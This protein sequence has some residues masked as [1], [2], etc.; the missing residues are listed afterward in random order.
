MLLVLF[1][2]AAAPPLSLMIPRGHTTSIAQVAFSNDGKLLASAGDDPSVHLWDVESGV[3]LKRLPG[4]GERIQGI[5]F[6]PTGALLAAVDGEPIYGESSLTVWSV[7]SGQALVTLAEKA[8]G[9]AF[10]P[11]GTLLVT[12]AKHGVVHVW[13]VAE[14]KSGKATPRLLQLDAGLDL[15][16]PRFS[17]DGKSLVVRS[18]TTILKALNFE[19]VRD[20]SGNGLWRVPLSGKPT[21]LASVAPSAFSFTKRGVIAQAAPSLVLGSKTIIAAPVSRFAVSN[22]DTSVFWSDESAL[23]VSTLATGAVQRTAQTRVPIRAIAAHPDGRRFVTGDEAG[24]LLEWSSEL[25]V[26]RRFGGDTLVVPRFSLRPDGRR[27]ARVEGRRVLLYDLEAMTPTRTLEGHAHEVVAVRFDPANRWLASIDEQSTVRLWDAATGSEQG[28]IKGLRGQA[29]SLSFSRDG[30]LLFVASKHGSIAVWSVE[31]QRVL[32]TIESG[33]DLGD[34]VVAANDEIVAVAHASGDHSYSAYR[35]ADGAKIFEGAVSRPDGK[36]QFFRALRTSSDGKRLIGLTSQP[37]RL[38][39]VDARTGDAFSLRDVDETTRAFAV[40]PEGRGYAIGGGRASWFSGRISLIRA[41]DGGIEQSLGGHESFILDAQFAD[42]GVLATSANDA[43]LR[44]WRPHE[45]AAAVT[46]TFFPGG[47]FAAAAP[48]GRFEG[49]PGGVARL[50]LVRGLEHFALDAFFERW[51]SPGMLSAAMRGKQL[52]S[53]GARLVDSPVAPAVVRFVTP[54]S[55]TSTSDEAVSVTVEAVDQGGG[56]DEIRLYQNGKLVSEPLRGAKKVQRRGEVSRQS[57]SLV[58]AAGA[59]VFRVVALSASRVESVAA[60]RTVTLR[61]AVPSARLHVV[62]VGI[63]AYEN[64]KYALNYG[65]PDAE[66][67][68][69]AL[70]EGASRIFAGVDR[71]LLFDASATK[72]G[73]ERALVEVAAKAKPEDAFVFYYAGHGAMSEGNAEQSPEFHLAPVDVR[74]L[75]GDDAE[76]A[77]AG[78]SAGRLKELI[79]RI[80]A[81][82]QLIVFDACQSGGAVDAFARRGAAEERAIAQLARATGVMVIAAT[83]TEQFAS[84]LAKLGHGVFTYALLQGLAGKADRSADGKITVKE[85]EAY[86]NDAVPELTKRYRGA[87]QYPTGY[88][89]GQDFPLVVR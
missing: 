57:F 55:D 46:M 77:R 63:N 27:L 48:D 9:V 37:A 45:E 68:A 32:R 72:L 80:P 41:S 49:T 15:D 42:N 20:D 44:I 59:N 26:R 75:Y 70:M 81:Q 24:N 31:G 43:T 16:E 83:E 28:V 13:R 85:I 36:T 88:G 64:P 79:A 65:R 25:E 74:Q 58:L 4:K 10:S 38:V 8:D 76:L 50:Y 5:S 86:L 39:H 7:E 69:S 54:S 89:R 53:L 30:R 34:V 60:E 67:F 56:V 23:H 52:P 21:K 73:I 61:A 29:R 19:G 33:S 71:T 40:A 84:E 82:K 6:D 35:V 14:L 2:V 66:G 18:K 51:Y 12:T 62:A 3:E 1:C 47:D 17:A 22:D 11:D 78:M 87:A